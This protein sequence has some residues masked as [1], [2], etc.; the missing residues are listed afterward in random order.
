MAKTRTKKCS[1]LAAIHDLV[2]DVAPGLAMI[3]TTFARMAVAEEVLD[4]RWPR[5]SA[6]RAAFMLLLPTEPVRIG[7][8]L[9][10]AHARELVARM[11]A[12]AP[13]SSAWKPAEWEALARLTRGE[14]LGILVA[15]SLRHPLGH[16]DT[17][18]YETILRDTFTVEELGAV[19]DLE[20]HVYGPQRVG[21]VARSTAEW[22][23]RK[24][25][26]REESIK[27]LRAEEP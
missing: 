11:G 4:A 23:A 6:P 18:M 19:A 20:R 12:L 17:L 2:E 15:A 22:L 3:R 1:G 5:A 16:D 26:E 13:D 8:K 10:R 14:V 9:Y 27:K 7:E 21:E 24:S 25:P